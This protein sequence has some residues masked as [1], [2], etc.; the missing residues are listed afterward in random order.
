MTTAT[1]KRDNCKY[2]NNNF[3]HEHSNDQLSIVSVAGKTC[4]IIF[5]DRNIDNAKHWCILHIQLY[6]TVIRYFSQARLVNDHHQYSL[7]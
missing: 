2:K 4:P 3:Y 5:I 6:I 7:I 1:V